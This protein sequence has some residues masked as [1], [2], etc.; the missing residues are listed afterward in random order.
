M[1]VYHLVIACPPLPLISSY[2]IFTVSKKRRVRLSFFLVEILEND[3]QKSVVT[4]MVVSTAASS[5]LLVIIVTL[6]LCRQRKHKTRR[7]SVTENES[8]TSVSSSPPK[9][10][11]HL[12][13]NLELWTGNGEILED[14]VTSRHST[15]SSEDSIWDPQ[16]IQDMIKINFG[17]NKNQHLSDV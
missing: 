10:S 12:T 7:I 17:T 2:V 9:K 11:R 6:L 14:T 1:I 8:E 5:I 16:I 3:Q 15:T 13:D 4:A